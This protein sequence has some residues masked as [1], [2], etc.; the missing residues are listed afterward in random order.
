MERSCSV[1]GNAPIPQRTAGA[2]T[3]KAR[4]SFDSPSHLSACPPRRC[5]EFNMP[6]SSSLSRNHESHSSANTV[7]LSFSIILNSTATLRFS[8]SNGRG[9]STASTS[10]KVVFPH[11]FSGDD[12]L[13]RGEHMNDAKE[14]VCAVQSASASAAP[15]GKATNLANVSATSFN[16]SAPLTDSCHSSGSGRSIARPCISPLVVANFGRFLSTCLSRIE[17]RSM[18]SLSASAPR[19]R[20]YSKGVMAASRCK[21]SSSLSAGTQAAAIWFLTVSIPSAFAK[22]LKSVGLLEVFL[23]LGTA[24]L[25]R[26]DFAAAAAFVTPGFP[27]VH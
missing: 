12:T 20:S 18:P 25:P 21:V 24:S 4:T 9:T 7:G 3:A 6:R 23:N 16:T 11:P 10:R 17:T 8:A 14:C 1:P 22:S 5:P 2:N 13:R 27:S 26:I 19:Q 15:S